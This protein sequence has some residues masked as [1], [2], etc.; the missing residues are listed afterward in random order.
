MGKQFSRPLSHLLH[1][2]SDQRPP[3]EL[4]TLPPEVMDEILEYA[5]AN[6]DGRQTLVACA[7]VATWWTGP[8][9]RRLFSS[10]EIGKRNYQR[11]MDG[12]AL[13]G[14]KARLKY[15]RSLGYYPYSRYRMRDLAQHSGE[16]LSA[17]RDLRGLT[18]FNVGVEH[19]SEEHFC[20]CFSAFRETLTH[21][22]LD[23]FAT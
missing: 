14:S 3:K 5:P 23:T 22:S 9:Q 21:L 20:A 19:I 17:L 8:S 6:R 13:S 12:V 15:V 11:W 1:P 2:K 16:Y 4:V 7:L 18:L 10:V